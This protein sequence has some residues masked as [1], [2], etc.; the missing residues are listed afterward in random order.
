M[1]PKKT[2]LAQISGGLGNQLFIIFT[3]I[4]YAIREN[5]VFSFKNQES[6]D[7]HIHR[8]TYWKLFLIDL[9]MKDHWFDPV[10][11]LWIPM[12]NNMHDFIIKEHWTQTYEELPSTE[13]PAVFMEGYFQKYAYFHSH[14]KDI[15][16]LTQIGNYRKIVAYRVKSAIHNTP[17]ISMHFRRG[18]Y[19]L[20]T[21]CHRIL[22]IT[23]YRAALAHIIATHPASHYTVVYFCED[24]DFHQHDIYT[25]IVELSR[26][27]PRVSFLRAET[28]SVDWEQMLQMGLYDH[29]II[30]NSSFSWWGA[31]LGWHYDK[32]EKPWKTVYYPATW[33]GS[34]LADIRTDGLCMDEWVSVSVG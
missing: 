12:V 16:A 10:K 27:F 32:A 3:A 19:L 23:Y 34:T 24:V 14:I 4:A 9:Q 22:E 1:D 15:L 11:R 7:T 21:D 13:S 2:I 8:P 26:L 29:H 30:A 25:M 33:Y 5:R 6:Y 28:T 18:D 17:T 31:Y 20:A